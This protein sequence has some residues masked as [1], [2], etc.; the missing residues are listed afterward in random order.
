MVAVHALSA[1][2]V[3]RHPLLPP[4]PTDDSVSVDA[5]AIERLESSLAT[6]S[7]KGPAI[8]RRFYAALFSKAPSV[9]GMFPADIASQEKKLLDSLVSVVTLLKE[10]AKTVPMLRELGRKHE[11]Y[12]ARPE[13]YPIVCSFLLEAM[14][15]EFGTEWTP[16]LALEWAQALELVSHH[17][18]ASGTQTTPA[19]RRT[20]A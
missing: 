18:I 12:G 10:P 15:A 20:Q 14:R 3:T 17:M 7:A 1:M 5:Q 16:Q 19:A 2:P 6:L 13:H 9:R 11:T 8:A 4:D